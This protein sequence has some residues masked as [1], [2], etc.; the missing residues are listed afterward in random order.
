VTAQTFE[1]FP[2][3]VMRL[4]Q[5][6][7]SDQARSLRE[8]FIREA[9]LPNQRSSAASHSPILDPAQDPELAAL[10]QRLLPHVVALGQLMFG[11]ALPWAIKEIW[12]NVLPAGAH[13]AVHNH[14]NCFVSGIVYLSEVDPSAQTVFIRS[15]GGHDFV[16][17]NS[18]AGTDTNAF[19]AEK[20]SAPA[21]AIGDALLFPSS[22]LHEVP[23][24]RGG[25][26]VTLA[27]NAIP[28]RLDACGYGLSFS[29]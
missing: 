9:T 10:T 1:I 15:L 26:R 20:W 4:T 18:H 21:P 29:A 7:D 13:Q 2:R 17:S 11:E 3:P 12:A 25:L 14:A 19:N 28:Q 8:R 6:L 23:L 16:F 24:N 22:M 5:V 27:F